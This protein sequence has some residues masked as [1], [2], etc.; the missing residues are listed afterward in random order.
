MIAPGFSFEEW[1]QLLRL[2]ETDPEEAVR[3]FLAG[4]SSSPKFRP[5]SKFPTRQLDKREYNMVV[6]LQD[7]GD[8]VACALLLMN[9]LQF[10][11]EAAMAE[12]GAIYKFQVF[13]PEAAGDPQF[14]IN[15]TVK[16]G[17]RSIF[18]LNPVAT[19]DREHGEYPDI[20]PGMSYDGPVY[21]PYLLG[22]IAAG[23]CQLLGV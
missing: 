19:N 5:A 16:L 22:W 1:D 10:R 3:R 20:E 15:V 4:I 17:N 2:N 8:K 6:S 9:L 13:R 11:S 23:H 14:K 7:R 21:L 12:A 18:P